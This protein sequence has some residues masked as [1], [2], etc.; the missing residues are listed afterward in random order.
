MKNALL[1][2]FIMMIGL[3]G[4]AYSSCQHDF[5]SQNDILDSKSFSLHEDNLSSDFESE[6]KKFAKEAVLN[7]FGEVKSCRESLAQ[8]SKDLIGD[9]GCVQVLPGK[10][11]SKNCMVESSVG[12]FFLSVDMLG[13]VNVIFNRWD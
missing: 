2:I 7:L 9:I 5:M 10:S 13:N 11:Y 1:L 6:G 4:Q 8:K 3:Q 12:Y